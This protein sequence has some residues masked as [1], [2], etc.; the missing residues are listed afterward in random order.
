[1]PLV[2]TAELGIGGGMAIL[3]LLLAPWLLLLR[4]RLRGSRE[5][6]A[7]SGALAVVTVVG[8]FDDYPWVGGPG[9]TLLWVVLG[10]WVMAWRRVGR[11]GGS[12]DVV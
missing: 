7:A 9:R 12:S 1:M 2:V 5:L 6:A 3:A 8:F 4:A 10:L 11:P